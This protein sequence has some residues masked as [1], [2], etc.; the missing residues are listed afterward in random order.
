MIREKKKKILLV[1]DDPAMVDVYSLLIK[2]AGFELEVANL[3][4]EA[5]RKINALKRDS[6]T[7]PDIIILD[8]VLPDINGVE[9]LREIRKDDSTKDIK[10]F[11]LTNQDNVQLESQSGEVK[12]DKFILK[13]NTTPTQLVE[14][15]KKELN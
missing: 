4:R 5:I 8:L 3:G 12:P 15:I 1:E 9:V 11:I 10:V 14:T 2:R 7:K 6:G 13:V